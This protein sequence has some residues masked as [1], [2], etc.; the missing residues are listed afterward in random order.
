MP[1]P[2]VAV[3]VLLT[4]FLLYRAV[5]AVQL[6]ALSLARLAAAQERIAAAQ[7]EMARSSWG[8][9]PTPPEEGGPPPGT[10]RH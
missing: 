6:F 1:G 3:L 2:A 9:D 4:Y 8:E 5:R 7:E 10:P